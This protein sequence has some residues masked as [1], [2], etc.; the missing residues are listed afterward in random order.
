MHIYDAS[1][2]VAYDVFFSWPIAF[3]YLSVCITD[4][5]PVRIF[6]SAICPQLTYLQNTVVNR[7]LAGTVRRRTPDEDEQLEKMLLSDEKQ[8]AEHIMLVDLVRND[9]GKVTKPGSVNVEKLLTV[10]WCSHV[11]HICSTVNGELLDNLTCCDALS[12]A[13]PVG[14]VSGSPKALT[15]F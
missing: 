3:F 12:A 8:C 2:V 11:M 9:V 10:E 13:L 5:L 7:P 6:W 14:A 15:F 1:T 4:L